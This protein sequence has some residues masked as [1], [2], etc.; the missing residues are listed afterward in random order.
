MVWGETIE[1]LA[2]RRRRAPGH[3]ESL[4]PHRIEDTTW[5]AFGIPAPNSVLCPASVRRGVEVSYAESAGRLAR[6]V[7]GRQSAS[8]TQLA[9]AEILA[10]PLYHRECGTNTSTL[11]FGPG[12]P[13]PSTAWQVMV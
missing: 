8:A 12:R 11:R 13:P 10:F 4:V 7:E 2:N 9:A 3:R 6:A 1:R 5:R